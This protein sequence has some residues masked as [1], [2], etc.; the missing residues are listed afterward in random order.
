MLTSSD[1]FIKNYFWKYV[2]MNINKEE[3]YYLKSLIYQNKQWND[4]FKKYEYFFIDCNEVS[5]FTI[6]ISQL[7]QEEYKRFIKFYMRNCRRI[8]FDM[9][10]EKP[11]NTVQDLDDFISNDET[12]F[13]LFIVCLYYYF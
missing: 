11:M 10:W 2:D 5:N 3:G 13:K 4:F 6:I 1:E 12:K 7:N 9:D 8:I